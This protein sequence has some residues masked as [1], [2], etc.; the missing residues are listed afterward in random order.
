MSK[1]KAANA[2]VQF[3]EGVGEFVRAV[4]WV[5]IDTISLV[6]PWLAPV[7]PASI[8]YNHMIDILGLPRWVA[9]AG[10][11]VVEA[12]GLS[13]VNT[14]FQFMDH[15]RTKRKTDPRAPVFIAILAAGYYLATVLLVNAMLS[16][17]SNLH[18][19]AIAMLSSLSVCA[20]VVIAIRAGHTR[21]TKEIER[22]DQ[23]RKQQRHER[24][25][26]REAQEYAQLFTSRE[27]GK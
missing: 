26:Q 10:A 14:T 20:A 1:N 2:A 11:V 6:T 7:L 3:L 19:L 17:A 5:L 16:N 4:E 27:G 9:L 22:A 13:V 18:R 21:R 8:A 23:E 25:Q 24:K 15:N 12:L